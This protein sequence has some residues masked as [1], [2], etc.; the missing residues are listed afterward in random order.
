M[1]DY[2]Q[3]VTTTERK[4]DAQRIARA[5]VDERLAAC[6]QIVGPIT[7]TYRWQGKIVEAEEW[8]CWAKSRRELYEPIERAIRRLHPYDEP[9]ILAVG[10]LAGSASYLAW[11]DGE[12]SSA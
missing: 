6:V 12:V 11:I 7:S 10:V 3:V 5:L 9:E 2:I 4:D 1:S 8:Q